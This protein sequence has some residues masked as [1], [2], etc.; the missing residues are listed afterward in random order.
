ME[1]S[2]KVE[3]APPRHECTLH[4]WTV[5]SSGRT[6]EEE[7]YT[8]LNC[9]ASWRRT[10]RHRK[11]VGHSPNGHTPEVRWPTWQDIIEEP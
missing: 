9:G 6:T 4:F 3:L 1:I 5:Q 2:A 11:P 8:C 7:V 10:V